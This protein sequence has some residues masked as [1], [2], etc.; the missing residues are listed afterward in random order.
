MDINERTAKDLWKI[1]HG[2]KRFVIDFA[3]RYMCFDDYND[4]ETLRPVNGS[5]TQTPY[6]M[7]WNI[8]HIKPCA[9]TGNSKQCNLEITNIV[10]NS[11]AGCETTFKTNGETFQS[12]RLKGT[13]VFRIFQISIDPEKC[14]VDHSDE[15]VEE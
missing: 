15:F 4:L 13:P 9:I 5:R 6:N 12:R 2:N 7:G 14:V 10:T 8:H 1:R 3:G 11:D